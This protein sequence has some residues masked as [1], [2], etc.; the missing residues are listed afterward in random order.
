[1][2]EYGDGSSIS[3]GA[4]VLRALSDMKAW[5]GKVHLAAGLAGQR[6]AVPGMGEQRVSGRKIRKRQVGGVA[7]IDVQNEV[8]R[9]VVRS[10]QIG[11]TAAGNVFEAVVAARSGGAVQVTRPAL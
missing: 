7:N 8:A 4:H 11:E 3:Q 9:L 1:M 2:G 6:L 10:D 5:R